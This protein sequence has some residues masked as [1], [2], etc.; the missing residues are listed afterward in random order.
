M[1]GNKERRFDPLPRE[2]SL[3]DLVPQDSFYRRLESRLD[4]SFVRDLIRVA[5]D[6]L[7][8]RW[9]LGVWVEPLFAEAKDRHG[10]RRFRLRR[11]EKLNAEALLIASCQNVKR[12]LTFG[13]RRPRRE[14]QAAALRASMRPPSH[15]L[16]AARRH[17]GSGGVQIAIGRLMVVGYR[18][19][20]VGN[21]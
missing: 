18:R 14:V 20:G 5:A 12:L 1:R 2:I 17:F 6:R 7:S 19:V 10:M 9:H 3:E 11:L 16:R 8:V 15:A 21:F 4:L 13:T